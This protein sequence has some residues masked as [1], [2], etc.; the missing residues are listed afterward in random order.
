MFM[1]YLFFLI[2]FIIGLV[3]ADSSKTKL[4]PI[5]LLILV[6][7]LNVVL[8][9]KNEVEPE[10]PPDHFPNTTQIEFRANSTLR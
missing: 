5:V 7:V 2:G 1:I 10:Y 4:W 6:L 8:S 3:S 9:Y